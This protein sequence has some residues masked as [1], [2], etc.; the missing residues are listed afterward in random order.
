LTRLLVLRIRNSAIL[1]DS[2]S[3]RAAVRPLGA[4]VAGSTLVGGNVRATFAVRFFVF[5]ARQTVQLHSH[6]A[7]KR[8]VQPHRAAGHHK[9]QSPPTPQSDRSEQIAKTPAPTQLTLDTPWAS[10][11]AAEAALSEKHRAL[12]DCDVD[13]SRASAA[14]GSV[15]ARMR[16]SP[17][18]SRAR[19]L[20]ANQGVLCTTTLATSSG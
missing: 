7:R 17:V 18:F 14:P 2:S 1:Y 10:A 13:D 15:A 5:L 12:P 11:G 8:R 20:V 4:V 9:Q 6:R 16:I 3:G 19:N